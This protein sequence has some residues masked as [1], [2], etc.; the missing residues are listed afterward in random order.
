MAHANKVI[1]SYNLPGELIC[2]DIFLRRDGSYG[3]D[4]YRRDPED[5]RG[6]YSIGHN[7]HLRFP[8]SDAAFDAAVRTV[9]WL[10]TNMATG[11]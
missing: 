8:T 4:E 11:G 9:G 10:E 3:F 6:W 2:V 7:G 5:S 1:G